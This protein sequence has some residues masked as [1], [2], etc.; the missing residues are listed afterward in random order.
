MLDA[1]ARVELGFDFGSRSSYLFGSAF[2]TQ[3]HMRAHHS[4]QY[5]SSSTQQHPVAL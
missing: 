1:L 3:A 4:V 5:H 2:R